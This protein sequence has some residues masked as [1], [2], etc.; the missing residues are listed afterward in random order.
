[1][2]AAVEYERAFFASRDAAAQKHALLLKACSLKRAGEY[3]QSAKTLERIPLYRMSASEKDS[4]ACEKLLLYYLADDLV[5]ALK[6]IND[7]D[8]NIAE[9]P[10]DRLLMMETLIY[11]ELYDYE[12]ASITASEY[13]R[14]KQNAKM[15]SALD[16]LYNNH[17]KLKKE[18][19]ARILSY[20]PGLGHMYARQPAE[21][22]AAFLL[23]AGVAAFGVFEVLEGNYIT[24][25][26]GGAGLLYSTYTG[27]QNR[28]LYL[29][30]KHNYMLTRSF[31]NEVKS[32]MLE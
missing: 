10:S 30:E 8:L 14:R 4:I 1:M 29:T 7:L 20:L 24:A 15:A 11:N 2:N 27:Q 3:E 18:K 25:W 28:A 23:N 19:T 32:A 17:P 16:S 9:N 12:K 13:A 6:T 21:G 26:M 31:N 5:V 22:V